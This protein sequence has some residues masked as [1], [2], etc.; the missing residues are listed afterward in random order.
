MTTVITRRQYPLSA[1]KFDGVN[2]NELRS[3]INEKNLVIVDNSGIDCNFFPTP[4]LIKDGN[5][6]EILKDDWVVLEDDE[7]K[8]YNNET[9]KYLFSTEIPSKDEDEYKTYVKITPVRARKTKSGKF[10]VV[11]DT[12]FKFV[13][14]PEEFYKEFIP[15]EE[16]K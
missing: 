11:Y 10:M 3:F 12:G 1:V 8:I 13:V 4:Y 9:F 14:E 15:L 2:V 6:I 16:C 7:Y 5:R